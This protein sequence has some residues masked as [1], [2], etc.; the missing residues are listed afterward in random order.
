MI[1]FTVFCILFRVTGDHNPFKYH[2]WSDGPEKNREDSGKKTNSLDGT[3]VSPPHRR[4][5]GRP[6]RNPRL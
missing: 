6:A 1:A 2:D 5:M 4:G 3:P